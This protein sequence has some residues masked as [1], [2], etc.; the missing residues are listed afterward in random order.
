M[1]H[2][3]FTAFLPRQGPAGGPASR[4]RAGAGP[5]LAAF[6]SL[7]LPLL[8][9]GC[10]EGA[11]LSWPWSWPW[12]RPQ[13]AV[14]A[15]AVN[16]MEKLS[17]LSPRRQDD[18]L[19]NPATG[20]IELF[21]AANETVSFQIVV[22]A[23]AQPLR[24]VRLACSELQAGA[25]K[26]AAENFRAYR[27]LPMRITEFPPWYLRL[28]ETSPQ[29]AD[30]YDAMVPAESPVGGAP[31]EVPANGRLVLWVDLA[32]PRGA[33][34]EEYA[35]RVT[36]QA[37][38]H[39]PWS[40]PLKMQVYDLVLP[41][42]RA[43]AAIGGFDHRTLL[44]RLIQQEGRA[45]A[46][47]VLDR[48]D[49]AVRRGLLVLRQIMQVGHNH[50]LDLFDAA[51]QPLLKRDFSGEVRLDWSDYDAIV[52]P[53][54]DGTAF[55]DRVGAPAWPSPFRD[56]WPD[57]ARY[58]GAG[59]ADYLA[60]AR[61]AIELCRDHFQDEDVR[62]RVFLWPSRGPLSPSGPGGY[63]EFIR[64]ARL[65]RSADAQTPI[66]AQ[67]PAEAPKSA[68]FAVPPEVAKL[69]DILA[70][71]GEW[72]MPR[73]AGERPDPNAPLSG[74]WVAPGFPPHF[75]SLG[76]LASPADVRAIP[77][78]AMKYGAPG[79]LIPDVLDWGDAPA[80]AGAPLPQAGALQ[81]TLFYPGTLAGIEG[82]LSSVRLKWLR[83]G[84][85][86][87]AYLMVLR[88]RGQA[89]TARKLLDAMV[90][91]A[92]VEAA[93]EVYLDA[94][95]DGWVQDPRVW[96]TA[97]RILAEESQQAVN[98]SEL[99]GRQLLAQRLAWQELWGRTARLRVEQVR[100]KITTVQS[101]DGRQY[102]LATLLLELYNE[103]DQRVSPTV[104]VG[105]LP[106]GW[107]CLDGAEARLEAIAPNSRKT[108]VLS[109]QGLEMPFS[110][111]AKMEVPL[112][113]QLPEGRAERLSVAIP[114]L[115]APPAVREPRIDG[116]LDDWPLRAGNRAGDFKLAGRRGLLDGGLAKRQ[117]E[118]FVQADANHLY[119]ALRCREP[120][121]ADLVVR[122]DNQ[123]RYEQ[124]M[125]C[126]EDLVEVL[127][128]PGMKAQGPDDL[129]HL[130]IKPSGAVIAERG[131]GTAFP[132]GKT[133]PWAS[134]AKV[135]VSRGAQEWVVELAIPLDAFGPQR[136][137]AF[138]GVNFARF[139]THG[140]ESSNWAQA[141]RQ[142][143][144]PKNLGTMYVPLPAPEEPNHG[145]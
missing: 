137:G 20:A 103:Y 97:R 104:R 83:R 41:D 102:L 100:T 129:Y 106:A 24:N 58:G 29:P 1:R 47:D 69:A 131:I 122:P 37:D 133:S 49:P 7:C 123:V 12:D 109:L 30:F 25:K 13:P 81:T 93:G 78:T 59:Q 132:L 67:L 42:A 128:D 66:L 36:V 111:V 26:I 74:R 119:I 76:V 21:A 14:N 40:V 145:K 113:F 61:R 2:R 117:T 126:G 10:G 34:S 54:L 95:L 19:I 38:R 77:W 27:L 116:Q 101:A 60:T 15:W 79:L 84:L 138:W 17:S 135:A 4:D 39:Q 92:G 11:D 144:H 63:E 127:L 35:G 96:I 99:S 8:A 98:P 108:V 134:G 88:Q 120:N 89:E 110:P 70:P 22:Q 44:S 80:S 46:P 43:I 105:P 28:S 87:I 91:Y 9:G 5:F 31:Y 73:P 32:V 56:D 142:L 48:R 107:E 16:E 94:R 85:Q 141:S 52:Q 121:M 118:A 62:K 143:Y 140:Q 45:F 139:A 124:L 114:S 33:Q 112:T 71:P 125:A 65:I 51:I 68:G 90:R 115:L 64:L 55:E 57:P 86:D 18:L 72:F 53:Y 50:R 23:D 130:V 136:P 3:L 6:L 82:V 75:P